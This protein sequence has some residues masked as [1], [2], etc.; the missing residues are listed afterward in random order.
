MTAVNA[1]TE[2][3][4]WKRVRSTWAGSWQSF[5]SGLKGFTDVPPMLHFLRHSH[6][7]RLWL[8]FHFARCFFH[9]DQ[10]RCNLTV[11]HGP[12]QS[13]YLT[14]QDLEDATWN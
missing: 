5:Q 6:K 9:I 8:V 1:G 3:L 7:Y 4:P 13:C 2:R 12:T 11:A 14:E 10:R